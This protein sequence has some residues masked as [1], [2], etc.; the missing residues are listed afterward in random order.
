MQ[1]KAGEVFREDA[2]LQGP[3]AGGLGCGDVGWK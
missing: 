1:G 2:G 3:D